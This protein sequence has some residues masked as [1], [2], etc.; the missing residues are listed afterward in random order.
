[1]NI[2]LYLMKEGKEKDCPFMDAISFHFYV[3]GKFF[4]SFRVFLYCFRLNHLATLFPSKLDRN[5]IETN[6]IVAL[7]RHTCNKLFDEQSSLCT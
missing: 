5:S 1:M 7:R 6:L 2:T 4:F 3:Q